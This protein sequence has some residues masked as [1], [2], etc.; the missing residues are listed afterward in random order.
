M[1]PNFARMR[2]GDHKD[3]FVAS[4][5][6]SAPRVVRPRCR[7]EAV[8]RVATTLWLVIALGGCKSLGPIDVRTRVSVD[9]PP[10][11]DITPIVELPLA[12]TPGCG[13]K[14]ALIDVDGVLVN[15]NQTGLMSAGYNP[16]D[17]F[18]AKLDFAA[19]RQDIAAVVLRIHSP[20]GGVTACDIMHRDLQRFRASTGRPVVACLMDV[21]AG[22]AYYLATAADEIVAHP[23]TVTGGLG[24]ILNLYN[25]EDMLAQ[26]NIVGV[27]IKAGSQV[28]IG[29]PLRMMPTQSRELLQQ[30][31]DGFQERFRN[32]IIEARGSVLTGEEDLWDGRIL[33]AQAALTHSLVDSIG[34]L[35]DA[36][37]SAAWQAGGTPGNVVMLQ[38]CR[39]RVQSIYTVTPNRPIQGDLMP[40]DV[41]GLS[42]AKLPTFLYMWQPDPALR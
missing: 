15:E 7:A 1:L 30:I 2:R 28:D 21:A 8:C 25:L 16:V 23:T 38:P 42:R 11:A 36:L 4:R 18:R 26:F 37:H 35:D 22:G 20:G 34:Y 31:A 10:V 27:S 33:T 24:V 32:A 40:I 3:V 12:G 29:S 39:Q 9:P 14:V 13:P 6:P 17:A 19:G 41:P 5:S